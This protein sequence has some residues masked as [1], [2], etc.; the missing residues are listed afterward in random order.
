MTNQKK[1]YFT[2][3]NLNQTQI[4]ITLTV[5]IAQHNLISKYRL[6]NQRNEQTVEKPKLVTTTTTNNNNN[7]F[8]I[9]THMQ[10]YKI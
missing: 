4:V 10:W 1:M 7:I 2:K 9:G 3:S 5:P 8:I 6:I